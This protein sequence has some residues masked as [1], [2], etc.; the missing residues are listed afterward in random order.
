M[1]IQDIILDAVYDNR[2]MAYRLIFMGYVG[3]ALYMFSPFIVQG[4]RSYFGW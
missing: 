2:K 1:K 3:F 4:V